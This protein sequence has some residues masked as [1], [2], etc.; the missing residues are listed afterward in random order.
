MKEFTS[1]HWVQLVLTPEIDTGLL[2]TPVAQYRT[3]IW[4]Q[5]ATDWLLSLLGEQ[6]FDRTVKNAF[7]ILHHVI[8]MLTSM[9]TSWLT[10]CLINW[11]LQWDWA[12]AVTASN[13]VLLAVASPRCL[14]HD[15]LWNWKRSTAQ[16]LQW[17]HFLHRL[18]RKHP[19]LSA[20]RL[21]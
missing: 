1:S 10:P 12:Q 11:T 18:M 16:V 8:F 15:D 2:E 21:A 4:S 3:S 19:S 20:V 6:R 13:L 9:G 5:L 17:W 7:W 14:Q